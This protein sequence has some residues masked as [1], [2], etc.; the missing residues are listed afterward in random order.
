MA[1][2][3]AEEKA[4]KRG[5]ISVQQLQLI[6]VNDAGLIDKSE[7]RQYVNEPL[8]KDRYLQLFMSLYV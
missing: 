7:W 1:K 5:L 6:D 3:I 4:G 2:F 8:G